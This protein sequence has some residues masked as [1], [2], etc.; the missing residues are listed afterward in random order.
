M[1]AVF[2]ASATNS[3]DPEANLRVGRYY[4][5]IRG[6]WEKGLPLLAKGSHVCASGSWPSPTAEP[7]HPRRPAQVGGRVVGTGADDDANQVALQRRAAYW[8][9]R[10]LPELSNG[11]CGAKGGHATQGIPPPHGPMD[12]TYSGAKVTVAAVGP[13]VVFRPC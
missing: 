3:D 5:L 10:V 13:R 1:Q 12:V 2:L 6:E 4:C 8:Y 7:H 11:L 9:Q